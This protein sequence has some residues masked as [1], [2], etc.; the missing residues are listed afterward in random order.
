MVEDGWI[1]GHR[2]VMSIIFFKESRSSI[3]WDCL[4]FICLYA[5]S[6]SCQRFTSSDE[7]DN[8]ARRTSLLSQESLWVFSPGYFEHA[9]SMSF[10]V[11]CLTMI[12]LLRR[13]VRVESFVLAMSIVSQ[14]PK[15]M[16]CS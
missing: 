9:S 14:W 13:F 10:F 8:S 1:L 15:S 4:F 2:G 16:A 7:F 6:A 5:I 12:T 11:R 3:T